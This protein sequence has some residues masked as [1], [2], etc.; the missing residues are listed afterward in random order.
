MVVLMPGIVV[1]GIC[2]CWG[3]PAPSRIATAAVHVSSRSPIPNEPYAKGFSKLMNS[4]P[5]P[6]EHGP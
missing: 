4:P 6:P 1:P 2:F 3:T 5:D